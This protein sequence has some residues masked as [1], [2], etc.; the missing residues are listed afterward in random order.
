[1][2][3]AGGSECQAHLSR[4][5]AGRISQRT[6]SLPLVTQPHL[7]ITGGRG[8]VLPSNRIQHTVIRDCTEI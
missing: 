8:V 5:Y 7:V 4:P 3:K 6:A 2:C 1:M